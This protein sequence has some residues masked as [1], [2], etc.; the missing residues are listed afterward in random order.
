[1]WSMTGVNGVR[2]FLDRVWRMIVADR[3]EQMELNAAVQNV[4]S[5]IEQSRVLH[6][7][8]AAVTND[9]ERLHFNTAIARMMEFT[10]YFTKADVRP[11]EVMEKFVLLVSPFAPHIAEEL[12][13]LLGHENT[14]AYEPW[15]AAN[16]AFVKD[17]F[18]E[19]PV[20]VNGKLR[21]RVTVPAGSD[22]ATTEAAARSDPKIAETI[23]GKTVVKVVVIPGKLVNF[24]VK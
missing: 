11:R 5:T 8:I 14:L 20:Q 6:K 1:P 7:T 24:V 3:A 4:P 18:V 17:D 16:P 12:W 22:S 21:G 10:N 13:Q 23:S 2:T 19:V 15:P 9:L